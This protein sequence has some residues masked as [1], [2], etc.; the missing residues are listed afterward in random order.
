MFL[1]YILFHVSKLLYWKISTFNIYVSYSYHQ[2][3]FIIVTFSMDISLTLYD[4]EPIGDMPIESNFLLYYHCNEH[5]R[6]IPS[7]AIY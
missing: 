4:S 6:I 3:R 5:H 7:V 2:F 1:L